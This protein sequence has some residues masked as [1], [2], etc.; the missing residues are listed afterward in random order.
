MLVKCVV[1]SY[2]EDI[3]QQIHF[4]ITFWHYRWKRKW[5]LICGKMRVIPCVQFT[6]VSK[7]KELLRKILPMSLHSVIGLLLI[8]TIKIT[9]LYTPAG[10][11]RQAPVNTFMLLLGHQ[12]L[13]NFK[14]KLSIISC[15]LILGI[16][17]NINYSL[18]AF[19]KIKINVLIWKQKKILNSYLNN[20]SSLLF[21]I[22][23]HKHSMQFKFIQ[24]IF[25]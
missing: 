9:W 14:C 4:S 25:S 23:Y 1:S 12:F 7:I 6:P 17:I 19:I 18:L 13:M 8:P 16:I 15:K 5:T 11:P 3:V 24:Y 20:Y 22:D 21:R 2:C 10:H